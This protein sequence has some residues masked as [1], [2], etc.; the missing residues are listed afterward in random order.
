[1]NKRRYRSIVTIFTLLGLVILFLGLQ[2]SRGKKALRAYKAE[3]VGKGERLTVTELDS[4]VSAEANQ[5]ADRL[6]QAASQLPQNGPALFMNPPPTMRLVA[7]GKAMVGWRQPAIRSAKQTNHWEELE[8][9]LEANA[10]LLSQI[11]DELETGQIRWSLDYRQGFS[12][13]LP[14]LAKLKGTARWLAAGTM[15]ALHH[16]RLGK[17]LTDLKLMLALADALRQEPLLISQLVRMSL[18]V[19]ALEST[20]EALQADGWN[21]AQLAELQNA[22]QTREFFPPME[23]SFQMERA[24]G[25][26]M[27]GRLRNS[28]I[29]PEQFGLSGPAGASPNP[30]T[31]PSSAVD[32]PEFLLEGIHGALAR[33]AAFGQQR[34][35]RWSWS[36]QDELNYVRYFQSTIQSLRE[37][38]Q[39][40]GFLGVR[41]SL[42]RADGLV[43]SNAPPFSLSKELVPSLNGAVLKAARMETQKEMVVAAVALKRWR[44]RHG[45]LPASLT[46]LVPELLGRPPRD[47]MDGQTLRYRPRPDGTFLLYSVNDDGS[48]DGGD[49]TP[50]PSRPGTRNPSLVNGRDLVWPM[51]AT[52]A[53]EAEAEAKGAKKII[54]R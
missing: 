21:D 26:L 18:A 34:M 39:S 45:T 14:H 20:W 3:L 50:P 13:L 19:I 30:V 15:D 44:L 28:A 41:S 1:M 23:K 11:R 9:D 22:W 43:F 47:F 35:W 48:D 8:S 4:P 2:T 27:F 52:E 16:G 42:D 53:E 12:L 49:A 46:T 31:W 25:I 7:P 6:L 51:P 36:Y 24:M 37:A 54:R 38:R 40:A 29:D 33:T 17:S 10:D 5:A 32:F